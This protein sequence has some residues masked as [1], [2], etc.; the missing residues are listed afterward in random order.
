[1]SVVSLFVKIM[2]IAKDENM[3]KIIVL[4]VFLFCISSMIVAAPVHCNYKKEAVKGNSQIDFSKIDLKNVSEINMTFVGMEFN[5]QGWADFVP[6]DKTVTLNASNS[7]DLRFR[8]K[9]RPSY[10]YDTKINKKDI[11]FKAKNYFYLSSYLQIM[12]VPDKK[13]AAK[14]RCK[15]NGIDNFLSSYIVEKAATKEDSRNFKYIKR[16]KNKIETL[17]LSLANDLKEIPTKLS[18]CKSNL[19]FSKYN[20]HFGS[21]KPLFGKGNPNEVKDVTITFFAAIHSIKTLDGNI[22]KYKTN[23]RPKY[24]QA[25]KASNKKNASKKKTSTKSAVKPTAKSS[26]GTNN[27]AVDKND[28]ASISKVTT[29]LAPRTDDELDDDLGA[30]VIFA[31]GPE[32]SL[33]DERSIAPRTDSELDSDLVGE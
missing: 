19:V 23:P 17:D 18:Y 20:I 13:N 14:L 15:F 3:K 5:A 24:A 29:N 8:Y 26:T 32:N 27:K 30:E 25:T 2:S 11:H 7:I 4:L 6:L 9:N 10:E 28:T 16:I 21:A 12:L 33:K 31:S 1:M 22:I